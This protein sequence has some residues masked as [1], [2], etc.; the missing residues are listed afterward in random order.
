[1][2]KKYF[3]KNDTRCYCL[4][5]HHEFMHEFDLDE[6]ELYEAKVE[7]GT[8]FFYCKYHDAIGEKN[9][10]CN[11]IDCGQYSPNNKVSGRC[12]YSGHVYEQT[13]KKKIIKRK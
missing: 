10:T 8:G 4:A 7:Y 9:E 13:D 11:K 3:Q 1:M 12:K 2:A 6:L 5:W